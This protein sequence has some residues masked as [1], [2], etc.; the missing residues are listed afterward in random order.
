MLKV[1]EKEK[2][3]MQFIAIVMIMLITKNT[4]YWYLL[5]SLLL[6]GFIGIMLV[7]F[8]YITEYYMN[9][10]KLK[11]VIG[12]FGIMAIQFSSIVDVC[13]GAVKEAILAIITVIVLTVISSLPVRD[14]G[15]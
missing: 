13:N 8:I 12:I 6:V 9:N 1:T 10:V 2:D 14:E 11:Q 15:I 5:I 7:F 3:I 4:T